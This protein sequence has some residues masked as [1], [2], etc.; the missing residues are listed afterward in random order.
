MTSTTNT[1]GEAPGEGNHEFQL[2]EAVGVFANEKLFL[3]AVDDLLEHGFDRADLSVLGHGL[4]KQASFDLLREGAVALADDGGLPRAALVTPEAVSQAKAAAFSL[5]IYVGT[6]GSLLALVAS[7]GTLAFAIPVAVAGGL[8]GTGLGAIGAHAIGRGHKRD[9]EE[10]V[11][12]GGIIL[13]VRTGTPE[14]ETKA[15]EIMGK[16][17]GKNVHLHEVAIRWGIDDVPFAHVEPD[18]LLEK[19]PDYQ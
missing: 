16:A 7:G 3:G 19:G 14:Q 8:A 4:D 2:R 1:G 9:I 13:W 11:A 12:N 18:P 15:Q 17:G 6:F 5:P 10:Q